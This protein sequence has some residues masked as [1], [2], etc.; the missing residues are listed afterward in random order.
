MPVVLPGL[1]LN[2]LTVLSAYLETVS[3]P[4]LHCLVRNSSG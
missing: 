2:M 3:Y 4:M 1:R